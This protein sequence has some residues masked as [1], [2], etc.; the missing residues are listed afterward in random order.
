MKL[1]NP[2]DLV[3]VAFYHIG[4]YEKVAELT[5][6][7]L[8]TVKQWRYSHNIPGEHIGVIAQA[9]KLNAFELYG[10]VK[11]NKNLSTQNQKRPFAILDALFD[12]TPTG[13]PPRTEAI[14]RK[15]YPKDKIELLR[16]VFQR[17][18]QR[19]E[20]QAEYTCAI[21]TSAQMLGIQRGSMFRL[22]GQ[23]FV[24]RQ[25]FAT[26]ANEEA[27]KAATAERRTRQ[28][29]YALAVIRGTLT[30]KE[31]AKAIGQNYWQ[32]L[33]IVEAHLVKYPGYTPGNLRKSPVLFKAAVANE[34][35]AD[36]NSTEPGAAP[37]SLKLKALYDEY[38]N[39]SVV[40]KK[41]PEIVHAPFKD[42]LIAVLDGEIDLVA[43]SSAT[44]IKQYALREFFDGQ[45][46][47]FG[48][49]F[50]QLAASSLSHQYFMAEILKHCKV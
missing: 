40:Y 18:Q 36:T 22:M 37:L 16:S 24:E 20:S 17:L 41:P 31:A 50:N 32:M 1:T 25:K 8:S 5:G 7:K 33:R 3:Q 23:F 44:N 45:L 21:D 35:A 10:Y 39:A 12:G 48:V 13:L 4:S 47:M 6:T 14:L 42:K 19:F 27:A 49:S 43:L 26:Q 28:K 2:H 29:E 11:S 9:A 15:R 34:I 46:A 30:G 38:H